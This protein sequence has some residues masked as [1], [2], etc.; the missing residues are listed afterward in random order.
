MPCRAAS[1]GFTPT[2]KPGARPLDALAVAVASLQEGEN[3]L[4][5]RSELR[6]LLASD[7][8]ALLDAADLLL[9]ERQERRLLLVVDQA[10][11]V[12]TLAPSKRTAR[13][14]HEQTQTRPFIRQLL[15]AVSANLTPVCVIIT[16][17][18]DFL[19]RVAEYAELAHWITKHDVIVSA[20]NAR[21]TGL[22]HRRPCFAGGRR[23]RT[24]AG[25]RAGGAGGRQAGGVAIAGVHAGKVVGA[26]RRRGGVT[27]AGWESAAA[28]ATTGRCSLLNLGRAPLDHRPRPATEPKRDLQSADRLAHSR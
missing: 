21:G 8:H 10:E 12:I 17:R 16:L 24:R 15:A 2:F 20:I 14:T 28:P 22:G 18:A 5:R 23:P 25:R 4:G 3:Q 7:D 19:H 27:V 6:Q 13:E 26:P 9:A 1:V 11:E